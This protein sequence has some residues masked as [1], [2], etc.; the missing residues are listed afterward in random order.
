MF[1]GLELEQ[2]WGGVIC[3]TRNGQGVF[4]RLAPGVFASG[5][6]NGV[7]IARGS[8]SGALLAEYAA[9]GG[10]ELIDDAKVLAGPNRVLTVV[11]RPTAELSDGLTVQSTEIEPWVPF[12]DEEVM[13]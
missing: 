12:A 7:G 1:A 10:S 6:Y 11:R 8:V 3:M 4:G 2:T 5:A 13:P 9:G